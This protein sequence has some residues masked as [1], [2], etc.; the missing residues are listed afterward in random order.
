MTNAAANEPADASSR[1]AGRY[2]PRFTSPVTAHGTCSSRSTGGAPGRPCSSH[3]KQEPGSRDAILGSCS[4]SPCAHAKMMTGEQELEMPGGAD[5]GDRMSRVPSGSDGR[6]DHTRASLILVSFP[7]RCRE[8][9]PSGQCLRPAGWAKIERDAAVVPISP[10][11]PACGQMMI[12]SPACR[13]PIPLAMNHEGSASGGYRAPISPACSRRRTRELNSAT[14]SALPPMRSRRRLDYSFLA[15]AAGG[16]C[17][18]SPAGNK[19]LAMVPS[20]RHTCC[21]GP[22]PLWINPL[23]PQGEDII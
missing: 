18:P 17:C 16:H 19:L 5:G 4:C 14:E 15:T 23:R 10:S 20:V 11:L 13:P 7:A 8:V 12:F 6:P 9:E 21:C 3:R 2:T 1:F 22:K